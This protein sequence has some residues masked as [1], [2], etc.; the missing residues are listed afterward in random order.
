MRSPDHS[1][2]MWRPVF[3]FETRY[4]VNKNGV[5]R[6]K[7][8][9]KIVPQ[10]VRRDGYVSVHLNNVT[11]YV[12][13]IVATAF[14]PNPHRKSHVN[15]KSGIKTDNRASKLEWATQQENERHARENGFKK[16]MGFGWYKTKLTKRAIKY[17][18]AHHPEMSQRALAR[19]FQVAHQTV[20]DVIHRVTWKHI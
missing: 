3:K 7:N 5:I 2:G 20:G 6:Q 4:E 18:R 17:I 9:K 8:T 16:Y 1:N 12:H 10:H 13:R 19:K 14:I 11:R 15:H